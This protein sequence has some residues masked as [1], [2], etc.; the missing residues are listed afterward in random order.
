MEYQ[1]NTVQQDT[2]RPGTGPYIKAG[3]GNLVGEKYR[4]MSQRYPHS[5][6]SPQTPSQQP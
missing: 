5:R 6:M 1:L 3:G 2:I 4:R